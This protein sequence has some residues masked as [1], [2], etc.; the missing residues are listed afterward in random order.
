MEQRRLILAGP[1]PIE[2]GTFGILIVRA[3]G[4]EEAEELLKG[5]PAVSSGT[6]AFEI[7]PLRLALY[8][9]GQYDA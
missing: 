8:E 2:P 9:A 3:N 7:Y 1:V 6:M 4:V 5:D